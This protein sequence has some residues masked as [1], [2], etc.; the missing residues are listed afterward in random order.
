MVD[1][2]GVYAVRAVAV[3]G[4]SHARS[5]ALQQR[6]QAVDWSL[7]SATDGLQRLRKL[8]EKERA[9]HEAEATPLWVE[10]AIVD[11]RQNRL[12]RTGVAD[13]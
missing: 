10:T 8:V 13:L 6:L 4:G 12:I 2:T 9:T 7:L 11:T 3:G 5:L 1:V